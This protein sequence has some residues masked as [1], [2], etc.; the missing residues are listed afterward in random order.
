MI[1]LTGSGNSTLEIH[2]NEGGQYFMDLNGTWNGA[3]VTPSI[4]IDGGTTYML[5]T[6]GV[7]TDLEITANYNA[8]VTIPGDSIVKFAVTSGSVTSVKVH[9]KKL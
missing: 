2:P 9:L 1:T 6:T 5:L 7:G 4:S 8:I 3:T